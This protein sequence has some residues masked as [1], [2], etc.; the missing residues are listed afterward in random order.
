MLFQGYDKIMVL[1]ADT[2]IS[3]HAPN[4]FDMC[5]ELRS[6]YAVSDYQSQ[7]RCDAWKNGPYKEGMEPSLSRI[8][9]PKTPTHEKFFNSGMWICMPTKHIIEMFD[10]AIALLPEG[11]SLFVEQGTLNVAAYNHPHISV[12]LLHETWNHIIPQDCEPIPEYY[13]NHFG[14]WAH[15]L[16]KRKSQPGV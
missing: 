7:N 16:L 11:A 3:D 14:G 8:Q 6:L 5:K 1:D 15:D 4:P 9:C 12:S 13:I 2:F 10:M